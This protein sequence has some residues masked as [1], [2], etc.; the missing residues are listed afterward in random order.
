MR[1]LRIACLLSVAA[2]SACSGVRSQAVPACPYCGDPV[3]H[4]RPDGSAEVVPRWRLA[5]WTTPTPESAER[6]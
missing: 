3:T 4:E 6:R 2:L 1:R 5:S